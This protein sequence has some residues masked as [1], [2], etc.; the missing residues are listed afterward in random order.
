MTY[1]RPYR[2][3]CE[4]TYPAPRPPRGAE[5]APVLDQ[6]LTYEALA[7]ATTLG[8][9]DTEIGRFSGVP[10]SIVLTSS[11]F[12]ALFTLRRRGSESGTL[13]R[14]LVGDTV[15]THLARDVVLARNAVAGSNA[16]VSV[17]GKWAAREPAST[18]A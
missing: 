10:D 3:A 8:D 2:P 4:H 12:G 9:T 15:E 11:A 6:F 1:R 7:T 13:I 18:P 17:V 5:G 14:V 16:V